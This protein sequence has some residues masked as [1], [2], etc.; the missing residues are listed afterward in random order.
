M[1]VIPKQKTLILNVEALAELKNGVATWSARR[2]LNSINPK[3]NPYKYLA[4]K[5]RNIVE[6]ARTLVE[7]TGQL[8]HFKPVIKRVS[9]GFSKKQIIADYELTSYGAYMLLTQCNPLQGNTQV[10]QAFFS[11]FADKINSI[12]GGFTG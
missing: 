7:A 11:Q 2:L 3:A 9:T 12:D 6:A 4:Y 8:E 5:Q 1:N 10:K